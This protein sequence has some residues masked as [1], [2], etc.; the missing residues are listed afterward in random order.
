MAPRP[1][2]LIM[3]GMACFDV[4]NIVSTLTCIR[5]RQ[6]FGLLVHNR[7]AARDADVVVEKIE[8]AESIERRANGVLRLPLVGQIGGMGYRGATIGRDHRD[9]ALCEGKI[10]IDHEHPSA[11]A[12]QQ[13]SRRAA[14][15]DAIPRS[16]RRKQHHKF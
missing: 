12:G 9:G 11:G 16:L 15:A 7:A 10:A 4:R 2:V 6:L 14:V 1:A 5:R 3:A 8:A 13:D